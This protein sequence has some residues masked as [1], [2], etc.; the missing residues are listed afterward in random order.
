MK[1][2]LKKSA[3]AAA[4][5]A[6]LGSAH[7]AT[8]NFEDPVDFPL[9]WNGD[10]FSQQGFA[11]APQNLADDA[12]G[13]V[14]AIVDNSSCATVLCPTN[15]GT[16]Y[17][18]AINDGIVRMRADNGAAFS[19]TSFDAAFLGASGETL[20]G[21][22]GLLRVEYDRADGSYI[23]MQ[24]LLPGPVGGQLGFNTFAAAS[25]TKVGGTGTFTGTF[26]QAFFYGFTCNTTGNCNAFTTNK[27][28]FALDNINV[29]AVPEPSQWA[30]MGLGLAAVGAFARRR[31]QQAA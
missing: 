6:S 7:A 13:M 9:F 16:Q 14:G 5:L 8:V 22:A 10:E 19:V 11:F 17:L 12:E 2:L 27:G 29:T 1:H 18:A 3:L 25:G 26:T 20:P 28:Q 30:L 24:Y 4:M 23:L 21:V 31:K 15:N